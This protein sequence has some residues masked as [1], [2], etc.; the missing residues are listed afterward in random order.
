MEK[1]IFNVVSFSGGKDSTAMLL[2]MIEEKIDIDCVLFCDTGLE[3]PQMYEHID[4]VER[5]TGIHITRVKAENSFEYY[6]F[7][8][9]VAR[10]DDSPVKMRYG[11][12]KG[13]GMLAKY[14]LPPQSFYIKREAVSYSYPYYDEAIVRVFDP[15]G[16]LKA[17]IN[18]PDIDLFEA[19]I[20]ISDGKIGNWRISVSGGNNGDKV[21]LGIPDTDIWGIRGEMTL[22]MTENTLHEGYMYMAKTTNYEDRN[23]WHNN[24]LPSGFLFGEASGNAQI[25]VSDINGNFICKTETNG[26]RKNFMLDPINEGEILK[27]KIDGNGGG[28]A[29]DGVPG[30]ICPTKEAAEE[31]K[32]GTVKVSNGFCFAGPLQASIYERMVELSETRNFDASLEWPTSIPENAD[33]MKEVLF[34]GKYSPISDIELRFDN[35]IFDKNNPYFGQIIADDGTRWSSAGGLA[36]AATQSGE[37]NP[38]YQNEAVINRAVLNGLSEIL[39]TQGDGIVRNKNTFQDSGYPFSGFF[40]LFNEH[41]S[42]T[43]LMLKDYL[44]EKTDKLWREMMLDIGDKA[45]YVRCYQSNQWAF[46]IDG[47]LNIYLATGEERFLRYFKTQMKAFLDNDFGPSSK[48][49]QHPAGYF[50]EEYGPDGNYQ[51]LNLFVIVGCY[52]KYKQISTTDEMYQKLKNGIEKA[53]YFNRFYWL[54]QPDGSIYSPTHINGRTTSAMGTPSYPG[55]YMAKAEFPLGYTRWLMNE[56]RK[57][58]SGF[59]SSSQVNNEEWAIHVINS[60][61]PTNGVY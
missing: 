25:S 41:L 50:L 34:V 30:L 10:R 47:H 7:D 12:V 3:F 49:G 56:Q 8:Y 37:L 27:I 5:E 39:Y 55:D 60:L 18:I 26:K 1:K 23:L 38:A 29:F 17:R 19:E 32:G 6:M 52:N 46:M 61:L 4:K 2:K 36:T 15:D 45:A 24:I 43:Y 54:K 53:L 14:D 33:L 11:D 58:N 59:G 28:V 9:P 22:G 35:Q 20:P 13:F 21:T 16:F 40:F 44:D 57:E 51:S 48:F 42:A 31:L